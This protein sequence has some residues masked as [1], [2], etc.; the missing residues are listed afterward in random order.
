[1]NEIVVDT[2]EIL[3]KLFNVDACVNL[4]NS[5]MG[6]VDLSAAVAISPLVLKNVTEQLFSIIPAFVHCM[7]WTAKNSM[8]F[9]FLN[10]YSHC[11]S[12]L[13]ADT[14]PA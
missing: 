5:M 1:M 4:V 7:F 8:S 6:W 9:S 13:T 3:G 11:G 14:Y 2:R 12:L 10:S